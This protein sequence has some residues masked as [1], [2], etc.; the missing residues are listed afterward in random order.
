MEC[1][2]IEL[3]LPMRSRSYSYSVLKT[4]IIYYYGLWYRLRLWIGTSVCVSCECTAVDVCS[5]PILS[6]RW[7]MRA[8]GMRLH[9]EWCL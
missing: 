6:H 1:I 7:H 8:H 3:Q 5:R 2:F 4:N 9:F